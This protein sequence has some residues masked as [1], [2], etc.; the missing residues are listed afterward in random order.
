MGWRGDQQSAGCGQLLPQGAIM[1]ENTVRV[2]IGLYLAMSMIAGAHRTIEDRLHLEL[3][4]FVW[5]LIDVL[6]LAITVWCALHVDIVER[7]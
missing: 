6:Y 4:P 5:M 3:H 7:S 1:I 2:L